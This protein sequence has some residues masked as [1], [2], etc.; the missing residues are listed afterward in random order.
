M[1]GASICAIHQPNFLPR[2]TTLAKLYAAD[3]W[4]VLDNVQFVR[5]DYQ[6]R[7]RLAALHDSDAWQW[8]SL[9]VHLPAGRGTTITD[10]Q[11]TERTKTQRRVDQLLQQYYRRSPHWPQAREALD[12]VLATLETSDRL[13]TVAEVSTRA[14]LAVVGWRGTIVRASNLPSRGGRSERLADLTRAVGSRRYLCGTGGAKYLDRAAFL[15]E[16]IDVEYFAAPKDASATWR[17]A[18]RNTAVWALMTA[19]PAGLAAELHGHARA[20]R[21]S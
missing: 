6:H 8:L 15:D 4:I 2:L 10:V 12:Q 9:P 16:G 17:A 13:A 5:R 21:S 20:W 19:G 1:Q 14:M 7:A 11:L 3:C 18:S